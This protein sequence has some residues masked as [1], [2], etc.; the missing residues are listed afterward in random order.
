MLGH[1]KVKDSKL[2]LACT[3]VSSD[4]IVTWP[5]HEQNVKKN[6]A[7]RSTF[8]GQAM[9]N[10]RG[11]LMTDECMKPLRMGGNFAGAQMSLVED[12]R[13]WKSSTAFA[14]RFGRRA[15][16]IFETAQKSPKMKLHLKIVIDRGN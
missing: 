13:S 16:N 5:Y 2:S 14:L 1:C 12:A 8:C 4:D 9:Q 11:M 6:S 3:Y 7:L 15:T 10:Q